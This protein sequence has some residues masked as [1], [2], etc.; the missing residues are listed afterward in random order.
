MFTVPGGAQFSSP[1]WTLYHDRIGTSRLRKWVFSI[2]KTQ[3]HCRDLLYL[4]ALNT[5]YLNINQLAF[6]LMKGIT[7]ARHSA[8][9]TQFIQS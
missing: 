2:I 9:L 1:G 6:I 3:T 7:K 4:C 8:L 5:Y